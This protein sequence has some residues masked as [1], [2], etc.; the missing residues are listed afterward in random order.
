MAG[1]TDEEVL[2]AQEFLTGS[3]VFDFET[4]AHVARFL[5]S[6]ELF[7][8]GLDYPERYPRLI[9]KI[10]PDQV[11]QVARQ[12]LDT[13]NFTTVIVGP[14]HAP[15]GRTTRRQRSAQDRCPE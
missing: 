6:A 15:K 5:L 3:F 2:V 1:P 8:L 7:N 14:N 13:V 11:A 9:R 10:T 12:H 4:N